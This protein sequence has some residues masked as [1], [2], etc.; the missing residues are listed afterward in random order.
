MAAAS[1]AVTQNGWNS[2]SMWAGSAIVALVQVEPTRLAGCSPS[3]MNAAVAASSFHPLARLQIDT[4][5]AQAHCL[6]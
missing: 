4:G 3:L 1:V 6:Q 2:H 5:P